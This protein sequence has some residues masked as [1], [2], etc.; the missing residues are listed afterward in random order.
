MRRIGRSRSFFCA[1][2]SAEQ[3]VAQNQA[4]DNNQQGKNAV[5]DKKH[6]GHANS[7]PEQDK[8]DHSLHKD[9][10]VVTGHGVISNP[11]FE[12]VKNNTL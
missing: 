6:D 10:S 5:V 3:A 9:T 8:T 11:L 2:L 7:N 1:L 4:K 12:D